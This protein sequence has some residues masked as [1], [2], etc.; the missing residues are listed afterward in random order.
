MNTYPSIL[1]DE[2]FL[3][4]VQ[5]SERNYRGQSGPQF[6]RAQ[7]VERFASLGL[8]MAFEEPSERVPGWTDFTLIRRSQTP[9][10]H[11]LTAFEGFPV[12][13]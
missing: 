11:H 3:T 4:V 13:P 12:S 1:V 5:E 2:P 8:I 9:A 7:V 10:R 6:S